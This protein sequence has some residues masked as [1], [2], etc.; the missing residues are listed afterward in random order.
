VVIGASSVFLTPTVVAMPLFITLT[1]VT[2]PFVFTLRSIASFP[3]TST[4][5]ASLVGMSN[6][7][8]LLLLSLFVVS[9]GPVSLSAL[10]PRQSLLFRF[11]R[12]CSFGLFFVEFSDM[13]LFKLE[14]LEC[15]RSQCQ[16]EQRSFLILL[17]VLQQLSSKILDSSIKPVIAVGV[18]QALSGNAHLEMIICDLSSIHLEVWERCV[19]S[20]WGRLEKE[21]AQFTGRLPAATMNFSKMSSDFAG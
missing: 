8:L 1:I 9:K 11:F 5:F 15:F 12:N 7:F 21:A 17:A 6:L 18:L 16:V 13:I 14:R 20:K 3:L 19:Q 2:S 4:I 10:S